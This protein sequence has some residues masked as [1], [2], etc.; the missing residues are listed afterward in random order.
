MCFGLS[1]TPETDPGIPWWARWG[2]STATEL[3]QRPFWK[4]ISIWIKKWLMTTDKKVFEAGVSKREGWLLRLLIN[5]WQIHITDPRFLALKHLSLPLFQPQIVY[6]P[7]GHTHT[8]PQQGLSPSTLIPS[9]EQI[10]ESKT[11]LSP[12]THSHTHRVC[13]AHVISELP[14]WWVIIVLKEPVRMFIDRLRK[15]LN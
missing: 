12:H 11:I 6:W 9:P 7:Q 15:L 2:Q 8:H 13:W 5:A 1:R 14:V 10:Q 4:V 3:F